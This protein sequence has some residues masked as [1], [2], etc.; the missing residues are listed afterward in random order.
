MSTINIPSDVLIWKFGGKS[1]NVRA[2]N[3][4]ANNSGYSLFCQA[5]GSYLTYKKQ[6]VGLNV[7]YEDTGLEHKIWL[8]LPDNQERDILT[9]E[10]FAFAI[11]GA[12]A[13]LT[14]KV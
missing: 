12:E 8:R 5:N 13:F 11:G 10:P 14:Y 7:G 1:G 6:L 2:Q 9:G 4:Y 3:T